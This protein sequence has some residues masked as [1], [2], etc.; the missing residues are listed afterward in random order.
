MLD[1]RLGASDHKDDPADVARDAYDALMQGRERVV[2]HSL[3]AKAVGAGGRLLPDSVK[4]ALNRLV[5]RP[6][7]AE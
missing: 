2:S 3:A 6:G 4:A 1:T 5:T 7:S